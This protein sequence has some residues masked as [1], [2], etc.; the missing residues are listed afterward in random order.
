MRRLVTHPWLPPCE[1]LGPGWSRRTSACPWTTGGTGA[2]LGMDETS[3]RFLCW[4]HGRRCIPSRWC[5][6]GNVQPAPRRT[7]QTPRTAEH[8]GCTPLN[9][10]KGKSN[11]HRSLSLSAA[12][13]YRR[14]TNC[15]A[16]SR[17]GLWIYLIYSRCSSPWGFVPHAISRNFFPLATIMPALLVKDPQISISK[18]TTQ[19]K[20]DWT[21]IY[22][23]LVESRPLLPAELSVQY[24]DR[25][26][27]RNTTKKT[28]DLL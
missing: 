12:A 15:G 13:Y 26:L 7:S 22:G 25:Q 14:T 24:D 17:P 2:R 19:I 8:S 23:A 10:T 3:W 18:S 28:T 1:T 4:A 27:K 6:A 21:D 5:A 16:K 9:R 20:C 11:M